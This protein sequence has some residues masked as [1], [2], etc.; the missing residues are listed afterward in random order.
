[1]TVAGRGLAAEAAGRLLHHGLAEPA[2][3][4]VWALIHEDNQASLKLVARLGFLDVGGG[5]HY[6]GGPHRVHV[7]LPTAG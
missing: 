3:P 5:A 6:G 4:A 7:A 1:M 2:V